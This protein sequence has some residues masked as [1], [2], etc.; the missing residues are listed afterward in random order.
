MWA[1]VLYRHSSN[2]SPDI[3]THGVFGRIKF[4]SCASFVCR[5]MVM[6]GD[7]LELADYK[8]L[9]ANLSMVCGGPGHQKITMIEKNNNESASWLI[10]LQKYEW[11]MIMITQ[12]TYRDLR[13]RSITLICQ[14]HL[15]ISPVAIAQWEVWGLQSERCSPS[16]NSWTA[17]CKLWWIPYLKSNHML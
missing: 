15:L 7:P 5:S 14:F 12:E 17:P 16:G 9:G 8:V 3:P 10:Q 2:A 13:S 4:R 1:S 11:S 6:F